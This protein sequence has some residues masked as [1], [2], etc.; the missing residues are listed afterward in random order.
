MIQIERGRW[1]EIHFG[2][3][4]QDNDDEDRYHVHFHP[5]QSPCF[6]PGTTSY[7][8]I[9]LYSCSYCPPQVLNEDYNQ[10]IGCV[11][12]VVLIQGV[13]EMNNTTVSLHRSCVFYYH[14]GENI[15]SPLP[16]SMQQSFTIQ[17]TGKQAIQLGHSRSSF[18]TPCLKGSKPNL[19]SSA[20]MTA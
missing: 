14:G 1:A 11:Q 17:V 19:Y 12:L 9:E 15:S 16:D 6:E 10:S 20:E 4:Y 7:E 5:G 13:D 2:I 18:C 8:H 3:V